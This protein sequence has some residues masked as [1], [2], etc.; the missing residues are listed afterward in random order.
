[1]KSE[2]TDDEDLADEDTNTSNEHHLPIKVE[3]EVKTSSSTD[4]EHGSEMNELVN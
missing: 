2:E 1:M 3:A 4:D